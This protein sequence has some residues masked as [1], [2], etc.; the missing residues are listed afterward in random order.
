MKIRRKAILDFY[1]GKPV[2]DSEL[3]SPVTSITGLIG[4]NLVLGLLSHYFESRKKR[5]V[6]IC[7]RCKPN[8]NPGRRLD[9]WVTVGI[10]RPK[11]YQVEVKNWCA[12]A[13]GGKPKKEEPIISWAK[14]NLEEFLTQ[15]RNSEAV[16]KVLGSMEPPAQY[17]QA[18]AIPLLAFWAPVALP[19]AKEPLP[20]FFKC[21]TKAY[22]EWIPE[23]LQNRH[24][25]FFVFSASLC[26]RSLKKHEIELSM[27]RVEDRLKRLKDMIE[28]PG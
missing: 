16:W 19:K 15:Q 26:L 12:H 22:E 6:K 28:I 10:T 17:P 2:W 7:Y 8:G 27:P 5:T 23:P 21:K 11:H 24:K 25:R 20:C 1:D 3:G 14:R 9:A 18:A 4:E 13:V